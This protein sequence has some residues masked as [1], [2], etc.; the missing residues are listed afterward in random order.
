MIKDHP[1]I[2]RGKLLPPL[3][4]ILVFISSSKGSIIY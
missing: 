2:E 4:G 1:D 3:D